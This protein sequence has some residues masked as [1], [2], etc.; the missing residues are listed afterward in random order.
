MSGR[1]R[2]KSLLE[3]IGK[4]AY[5]AL[6]EYEKAGDDLPLL[7]STTA[8]PLDGITDNVA[9]RKSIRLLEGACDQL[10]TSLAPPYHTIINRSEDYYWAC[11]RVASEA[12]IADILAEHPDGLHV[13]K[14]AEVVKIEKTKLA[15]VL[16]VLATRNCF[17]EVDTNVFA[18]NR[19]SVMLLSEN[20]ISYFSRLCTDEASQAALSLYETLTDPTFGPSFE[21]IKSPF[22]YSVRDKFSGNFLDYI[23]PERRK[24][25]GRAML[26]LNKVIGSDAVLQNFPWKDVN[27]VCDVGSGVGSFAL[28]LSKTYPHVWAKE[29]PEAVEQQHVQFLP[30]DFF[31]EIPVEGQDVYYL[32]NILHTWPDADAV[33]ILQSLR[34]AMRA[35]SR[36][37]IHDYVLQHVNRKDEGY[38]GPEIAPE[39]LLPNFGHGNIRVYNQD[40]VMLLIYNSR[41]RTFEDSVALSAPVGLK[42]EKVWDLG[43]TSVLEY[44]LADPQ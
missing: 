6:E 1:E 26:G 24:V 31:K 43:E 8:H 12:R 23:T 36:L 29:N 5:Q 20:P 15:R 38:V 21:T 7:D 4:A 35:N 44:R 40:L 32:R 30:G 34:K 28:P 41:E 13:E 25:F 2:I 14:L 3:L 37:L 27:T 9:L 10:V 33:K 39:P 11:M 18:N 19:L 17:R 22:L 42:L 16:M